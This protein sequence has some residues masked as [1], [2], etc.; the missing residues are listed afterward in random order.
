MSTPTFTT[1]LLRTLFKELGSTAKLDCYGV[2]S[3]AVMPSIVENDQFAREYMLYNVSRKRDVFPIHSQPPDVL[4]NSLLKW[5]DAEYSCR[6][7]NHHGRYYSAIGDDVDLF[8]KAI[9]LTRSHISRILSDVWPDFADADF[10]SGATNHT[11]REFSLQGA[12]WIGYAHASSFNQSVV[13]SARIHLR[14][15]LDENQ[16]YAR[17]LYRKRWNLVSEEDVPRANYTDEAIGYFS[18]NCDFTAKLAFVPKD[19]KS[20]RIIMQT[21]EGTML[22][23]RCFGKALRKAL[24][25]EGVDL[26]NQQTNQDW[27]RFGSKT[28]LVATIDLSSASDTISCGTIKKFLPVRWYNWLMSCRDSQVRVGDHVHTLEKIASNGNGFCF[29]LESLVF[30][31]MTLACTELTGGDTSFV[32]IY[33]DDIILPSSGASLL[34]RFFLHNGFFINNDKSFSGPEGFRESCGGHFYKGQ[35]VTPIYIKEEIVD[36]SDKFHV[37]NQLNSWSVRCNIPIPR[38]LLLL[39]NSIPKHSRVLVPSTYSTKSGLHSYVPGI[40]LPTTRYS[41]SL[42][43]FV[44]RTKVLDGTRKNVT[45]RWCGRTQLLSWFVTA[46]T[47][48]ETVHP[49]CP[50]V[51]EYRAVVLSGGSVDY[52]WRTKEIVM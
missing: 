50:T 33:G 31:A 28:G 40:I 24:L 47:P 26:G 46:S 49:L 36:L 42:Q 37:F 14:S 15:I 44:M 22:V 21:G 9:R 3:A 30:Y 5:S 51:F 20:V 18:M 8:A 23:Q 13:P 2:D 45:E 10:T 7:V 16:S 32:S 48:V 34:S 6:V 12:K 29:E 11:A 1:H 43:R 4:R 52:K 39:L 17:R 19:F 38:T 41:S 25:K 35:D 27:A